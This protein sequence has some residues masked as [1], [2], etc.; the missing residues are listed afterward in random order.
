MQIIEYVV[1]ILPWP[2]WLSGLSAGLQMEGSPVPV[3][4]R[5]H[6]WVVVQVPSRGRTRGNH[7]LMFLSSF[8]SLPLSLKTNKQINP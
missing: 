3:P 7:R 5:A 6:A 2:V 1:H 8:S 4:V